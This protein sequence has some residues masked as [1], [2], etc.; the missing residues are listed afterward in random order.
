[1][2]PQPIINKVAQSGIITLNLENFLPKVQEFDLKH[3]LYQGL[4]LREKDFREQLKQAD[5]S[6][7]QDQYVALFCS[8]DAI[9]PTWA[10][11]LVTTH[12]FPY[13]S[14]IY[15]AKREEARYFFALEKITEL[16][17]S[18]YRDQRLVIKGCGIEVVPEF[19]FVA[20]MRKLLPVVKSIM[21]GEPCSTVPLYKRK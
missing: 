13:T 19:L 20:L 6:I 21:Y 9:I 12:L 18:E 7:F 8:E 2:E 5:F 3:Y 15:M 1:M 16:D 17:L 14:R 10:Y 4:V 11:M